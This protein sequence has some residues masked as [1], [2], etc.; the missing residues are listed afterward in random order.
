[1]NENEID[2]AINMCAGL[3]LELFAIAET[4]LIISKIKSFIETKARNE[5]TDI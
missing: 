5:T 1:M 4:H 2:A 3:A